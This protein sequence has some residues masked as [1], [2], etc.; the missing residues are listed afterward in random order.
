[1]RTSGLMNGGHKPTSRLSA[2]LSSSIKIELAFP[3][4]D[5]ISRVNM[6]F[7]LPSGFVKQC[8]PR[9]GDAAYLHDD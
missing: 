6:Y 8:L 2:G 9:R 3:V 4:K 1:M 7:G 5:A